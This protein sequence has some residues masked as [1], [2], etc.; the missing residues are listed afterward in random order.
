MEESKTVGRPAKKGVGYVKLDMFEGDVD[1]I[2]WIERALE[3]FEE[4]K[5][6]ERLYESSGK[7]GVLR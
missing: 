4:A 1:V 2:E 6:Y 3:T 5:R 7:S